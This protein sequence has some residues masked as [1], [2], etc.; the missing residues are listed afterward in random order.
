V[1]PESPDDPRIR[2]LWPYRAMLWLRREPNGTHAEI[3]LTWYEFSRFHPE[4][5]R[6][7]LSIAFAFVATHNHFVLDRGGKV[8]KQSA[9]IIKLPPDATEDDHLALLAYLNSSTAC[10]WMKQVC[11]GKHS[12]EHKTHPDPERN[13][14]EFSGTAV[15]MLPLPP[16]LLGHSRLI[17]LARELQRI[18]A[19]RQSHIASRGYSAET[20]GARET[21]VAMQEEID[22]IIYALFGLSDSTAEAPIGSLLCR[23]GDRPFERITP[24][25]SFVRRGDTPIPFAEAEV[26]STTRLPSALEPIWQERTAEAGTNAL[27]QLIEQPLYKRQWRDSDSNTDEHSLRRQENLER[28]NQRIV[29]GL[30]ATLRQLDQ[31]IA[32]REHRELALAESVPFLAAYR[33]SPSGLEKHAQWQHTWALQRLEDA[34]QLPAGHPPIPVPPKYDPR[35]YRDA[36]TWRLRGKLDVPKERF[37]RYPG[38]ELDPADPVFGWAGWDHL[39]RATALAALYEQRRSQHAWDTP[40][41]L[42]LLAGLA[43]LLPWLH[44]WHAAHDPSLGDSPARGFDEYL[45]AALRDHG[46]T[47]E[48]VEGWRP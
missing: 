3:G 23:R 30:E 48:G 26:Q 12:A 13:R 19:E 5:F 34:G 32:I 22:W 44:Q 41:L 42:P 9:P 18:A 20:D 16:G 46:L 45:R 11:Q 31:P 15:G 36:T 28:E 40:R 35:D 37:I 7:G 6:S 2:W 17:E 27:L 47:L 4:R 29:D 39:Q 1:C 25:R 21:M 24:R 33:Y 10:F 14:Y 43:E 8:F 38:C